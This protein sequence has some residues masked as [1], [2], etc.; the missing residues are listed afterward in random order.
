MREVDSIVIYNTEYRPKEVAWPATRCPLLARS[1]RRPACA[2]QWM[3]E[4][5][6]K[7]VRGAL[8]RIAVPEKALQRCGTRRL[9]Q[10][11]LVPAGLQMSRRH[12]PSVLLQQVKD[13]SQAFL[14]VDQHVHLSLSNVMREVLMT[15]FSEP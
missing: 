10:H 3:H 14:C 1:D 4:A 12:R 11:L 9:V 2:R 15:E 7:A 8:R 6:S 13:L 5:I